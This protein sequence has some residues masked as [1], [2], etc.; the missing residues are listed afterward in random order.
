MAIYYYGRTS[1]GE[2]PPTTATKLTAPPA[3]G[4]VQCLVFMGPSRG[5]EWQYSGAVNGTT[6]LYVCDYGPTLG[7]VRSST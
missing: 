5:N 6:T 3:S 2:H 7:R 4:S 1:S